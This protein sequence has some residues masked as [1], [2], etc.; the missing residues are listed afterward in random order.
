MIRVNRTR[1]TAA[2]VLI[3]TAVFPARASSGEVRWYTTLS[4]A[5][6]AALQVNK[7]ILVEFWSQDCASCEAMDV[8]VFSDERVASALSRLVPVRI[9]VDADQGTTRK[10]N[11]PGTPT[12][13]LTDSYG[14]ELFRHVGMLT[15]EQMLPLLDEIPGDI[16]K[17]NTLSAA[18][19]RNRNDFATLEALGHELRVARFYRSSNQYYSRALRTREAE[20]RAD[21]R[22]TILLAAGRNYLELKEVGE[23][24]KL[25]KR[26]VREHKGTPAAAEAARLLAGL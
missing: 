11:V 18:L 4:Q 3:A 22:A 21:A 16:T 6:P 19:A 1:L 17:I 10:Y 20:Q 5:S 8:N 26:C 12:L 24:Q 14:N 9:D 2:I 7:P 13:I 15:L 25:L 23:A